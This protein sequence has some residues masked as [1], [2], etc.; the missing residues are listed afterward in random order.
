MIKLSS[1]RAGVSLAV[2]ATALVAGVGTAEAR[3]IR[4]PMA[5]AER[6]VW[7]AQAAVEREL[8]RPAGRGRVIEVPPR[9]ARSG[10]VADAGAAVVSETPRPVAPPPAAPASA[11]PPPTRASVA[12]TSLEA[13]LPEPVAAPP[14]E[15]AAD[16]TVSVLVRPAGSPPVQAPEPLRFP[17]PVQP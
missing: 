15:P 6:R 10:G 3:P 5:R 2:F 17:G 16:G 13:P 11:A 12:R 8:A 7:R 1:G 14:A 4:G 9:P